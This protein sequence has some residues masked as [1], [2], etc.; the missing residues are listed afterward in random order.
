MTRTGIFGGSFNPIHNAHLHLGRLFLEA[1]GL[2]ELWFLVSPQNP[3]KQNKDLLDEQLRLQMVEMALEG[4][5]RMKACDFEFS[6][7]RPSFM[8]HTLT[9]MSSRWPDREFALLIGGDNWQRFGLWFRADE[10]I[11]SYDLYIYPR[12]DAAIDEGMLP[13][14]VHLLEAELDNMSSTEIRR[15][16]SRGES[17]DGLV[18]DAVRLFIEQEGLYR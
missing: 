4:D 7:P 13:P 15:R 17:I 5:E 18:P 10:I 11:D 2:D 1:A 8:I 6:L 3:L 16:I 9:E 14:T 12:K